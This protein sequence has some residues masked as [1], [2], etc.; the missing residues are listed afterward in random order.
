MVTRAAGNG[1]IPDVV[2]AAWRRAAAAVAAGCYLSG[3]AA[4]FPPMA[5]ATFMEE[6]ALP[7]IM[8]LKLNPRTQE[9]ILETKAEHANEDLSHE[10]F[11]GAIY[12]EADLRGANMSGCD[13]RAAIFS[14][15]VMPKVN[16]E[17]R[18]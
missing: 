12:T 9:V 1:E 17:G 10:D 4:A 13:M 16:L 7:S 11:V 15:A 2:P 14:R 18:A 5:S 3:A 6:L 8:K